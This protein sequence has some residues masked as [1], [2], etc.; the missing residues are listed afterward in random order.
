M[1]SHDDIKKQVRGWWD[2]SP[3]CGNIASAAVGTREFFEQV[4]AY[5][6]KYE[7]FTDK[8]ADYGRWKDKRVLEIGCGLGKDFAR[9]VSGGS[10]ATTV[11]MSI[12]SLRL[13]KKRLEIFGLKGNLCLAD[14]ENFPLKTMSLTWRFPGVFFIIR[15]TPRRPLMKY[16][17][18]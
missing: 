5:K 17:A 16:I 11:D 14:A 15:R 13:T 10:M 8:I 7:A 4:D 18:A 1:N 2:N 3:C 9:F 6:D 12:E